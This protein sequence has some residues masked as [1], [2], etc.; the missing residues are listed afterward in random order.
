[1]NLLISDRDGATP[2]I[3]ACENGNSVGCI[4]LL[5]AAGADVSALNSAGQSALYIAL[6]HK[7]NDVAECVLVWCCCEAYSAAS[8]S[9]LSQLERMKL[10]LDGEEAPR[11]PKKAPKEKTAAQK[12]KLAKR[13]KAKKLKAKEKKKRLAAEAAAASGAT[14]TA[15][16]AAS[17]A[18]APAPPAEVEFA[19]D[20][21][22]DAAYDEGDDICLE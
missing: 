7:N 16:A 3:R 17:S 9:P 4:E 19:D 1:M 8:A 13:R 18:P 10:G 11:K 12:A 21:L 22:D 2:L 5:I 14:D 20:D 15:A 6:M